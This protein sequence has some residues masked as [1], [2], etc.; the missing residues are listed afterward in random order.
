MIATIWWE[1]ILGGS[2]LFKGRLLFPNWVIS[3]AYD[4]FQTSPGSKSII[5]WQFFC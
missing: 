3:R 2:V 4:L 5:L 1:K